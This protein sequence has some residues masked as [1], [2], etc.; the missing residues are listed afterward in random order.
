MKGHW[1]FQNQ[2][3]PKVATALRRPSGAK[4]AARTVVANGQKHTPNARIDG[5]SVQQ[6][7]APGIEVI[8]G[9]PLAVDFATTKAFG[10][11]LQYPD[12]E[13]AIHDWRGFCERATPREMPETN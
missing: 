7:A 6:M 1:T 3:S 5:V 4:A 13:G 11:L 9:D 10:A 2:R 8:V 12:T